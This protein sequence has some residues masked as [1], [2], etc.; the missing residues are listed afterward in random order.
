[1][2]VINLLLG[3]DT[4]DFLI[5]NGPHFLTGLCLS[6]VCGLILG[7]ERERKEKPA[8]LRTLTLISMGSTVFVYTAQF[9]AGDWFDPGRVVGQIVTGVG[10]IGGGAIF[11]SDGW[12]QGVT[13][14]ATIWIAAAIGIL[15][16]TG[17]HVLGV[18]LTAISYGV[19]VF[20]PYVDDLLPRG[21]EFETFKLTLTEDGQKRGWLY[22]KELFEKQNAE[23]KLSPDF[24]T[25]WITVELLRNTRQAILDCGKSVFVDQITPISDDD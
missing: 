9:V 1:M 6:M 13:T 15:I 4:Y 8:G 19:L 12:V 16:G 5:Q 23:V 3:H 22:L 21:N 7:H 11:R 18:L 17:H 2:P 10:F 25:M 24:K 14:A 20:V